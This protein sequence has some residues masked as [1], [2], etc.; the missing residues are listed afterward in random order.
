MSL[1][2]GDTQIQL[3]T[4]PTEVYQVHIQ[5]FPNAAAGVN[6]VMTLTLSAEDDPAT[7][8]NEGPRRAAARRLDLSTGS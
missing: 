4:S 8:G 5:I 2:H 7:L 1:A 6:Q 3:G